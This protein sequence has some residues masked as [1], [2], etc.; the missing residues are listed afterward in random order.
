MLGIQQTETRVLCQTV[1]LNRA[2]CLLITKNMAQANQP[3]I[4]KT[5]Q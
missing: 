3:Q 4:I 2:F 1:S 5:A